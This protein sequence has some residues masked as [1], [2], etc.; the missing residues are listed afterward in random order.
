MPTSADEAQVNDILS[1]L[2]GES[3]DSAR[4][5]SMA[6]AIGQDLGE[7]EGVQN[8]KSV[9]CKRS[10]R[11][12]YLVA[13]DEEKKRK[14]RLRWLSCLEQ[15]VDPLTSLGCGPTGTT[16]EDNIGGCDDARV[17]GRV[18]DED[19][20]EEEEEI[21]L[22][23]KNSRS[24]RR[25]DIPMLALS[26]LVSLQGLTM[27][28]IDHA[29]ER[30]IPKNLLSEP[31]EVERSI[32]RSK[33]PDDV[34]LSGD[35]VRQEVT[36]TVSHALS[37]LEGGLA[38]E[39]TLALDV[40]GQSHPAPLGTTEGV[41]ASEGAAKDVLAPEGGA[42]GDPALNDARPGSSSAASM[43]V[44]V[45][46]PLVQSEEPVVMNLLAA[47]VGTVTLE[48]SDPDARN[49]PPAD[50]AEVS[51]SDA[52]NIV[53]VDAPST[54]STS[55]LPALGLPLFLSNLQVSRPLILI[56]HVG[57]RLLLLNFEI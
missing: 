30:I 23:R 46:S 42:E 12:S 26:G 50:G 39:D 52:F 43:D 29:L 41:S 28:A 25:S 22:I 32:V 31:T 7:D 17:G 38:H 36:W 51:P 5:E 27:A 56:I 55:M 33:V 44:H 16:I 4:T 11:T 13:P 34:P 8:P 18:I 47:L 37:T 15:D 9:C 19:E 2:A 53:P 21:P 40:A 14:K 45:G 35:P 54:G 49:L 6:V 20:E 48:A 10:R 1:M 24:N 57:K 3:F